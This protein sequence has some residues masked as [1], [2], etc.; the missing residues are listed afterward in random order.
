M[1]NLLKNNISTKHKRS[2]DYKRKTV[3][4]DYKLNHSII[5]LITVYFVTGETVAISL[6]II[7]VAGLR[8]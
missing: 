4:N 8:I 6:T 1:H 2:H 7:S 5:N 3:E